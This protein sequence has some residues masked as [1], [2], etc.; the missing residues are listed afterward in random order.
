[1]IVPNYIPDPLEVPGNVTELPYVARLA[2]IRRVSLLITASL[3]AIAAVS[4]APLP[5]MGLLASLAILGA[6]LLAL[7]IWRIAT[8]GR[9]I[10]A[11][12]S[13]L[14]LPLVLVS[15]ALA[16]KEVNAVG[17]PVWQV[18][19]GSACILA[20][21]MLC[22]RDYS[23]VGNFLLS[24]IFSSVLIAAICSS[25]RLDIQHSAFALAT[26]ALAMGYV[27]YDLA[28]LMSRRRFD[29]HWAAVTDIY[30]DVFNFFGYLVR[31]L[32]HWRKHRL[33]SVPTPMELPWRNRM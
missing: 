1:V 33:W 17:W 16:A 4:A 29:E 7:E 14:A 18:L 21:T 25:L 31:V 32:R 15:L 28:S 8:R 27:L 12:V 6:V 20:Y 10:E 24:L 11:K 19:V 2:F 3:T 5:R 30:R 23:F 13:G 26:N 22:G 9:Q